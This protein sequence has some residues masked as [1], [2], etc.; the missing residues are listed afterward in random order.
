M[1]D[2]RD[3]VRPVVCRDGEMSGDREDKRQWYLFNATYQR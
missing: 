1:A 2:L 3:A